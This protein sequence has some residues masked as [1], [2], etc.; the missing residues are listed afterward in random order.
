M[1]AGDEVL[2]RI[3]LTGKHTGTFLGVPATG[4]QLDWYTHELCAH[5]QRP[6]RRTVGR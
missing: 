6:V 5:R 3:R 1:A 2:T 4:N